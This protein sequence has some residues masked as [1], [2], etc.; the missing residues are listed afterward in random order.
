MTILHKDLILRRT[1]NPHEVLLAKCNNC[2]ARR[3]AS[4]IELHLDGW[5]VQ[6]FHGFT[7]KDEFTLCPDCSGKDYVFEDLY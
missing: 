2:F 7:S 5:T 3:D 6:Y 4:R 1:D